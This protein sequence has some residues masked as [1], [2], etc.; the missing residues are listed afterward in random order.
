[1]AWGKGKNPNEENNIRKAK[2][3]NK[4]VDKTEKKINKLNRDKNLS[5]EEKLRR[6][7]EDED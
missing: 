3:E 4:A 7:L 1:M 5:A 6:L 2:A